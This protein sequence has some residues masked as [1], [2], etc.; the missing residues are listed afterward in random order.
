MKG[1]IFRGNFASASL[2]LYALGKLHGAVKHFP[3][4]LCL[5]LIEALERGGGPAG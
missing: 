2:K 5:G 4:Q 3:R 1:A